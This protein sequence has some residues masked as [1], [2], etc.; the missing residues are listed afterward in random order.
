MVVITAIDRNETN[1]LAL[2]PCCFEES[3]HSS[4]FKNDFWKTQSK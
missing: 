2:K 4:F 1:N 3:F